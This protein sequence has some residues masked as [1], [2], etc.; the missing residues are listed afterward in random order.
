[1][2]QP[3]VLPVTDPSRAP[4]DLFRISIAKRL[5][6]TLPLTLEEALAGV[7]YGK[8]GEDFTVA[9]PRY[10]LPGK[11]EELAAKVTEGVSPSFTHH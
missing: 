7:D 2:P 10:R 1:M 4:L 3:P 11:A 8:K 5:S 6:D 9:L